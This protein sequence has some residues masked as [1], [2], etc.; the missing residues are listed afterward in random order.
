MS[1]VDRRRDIR[2]LLINTAI[3]FALYNALLTVF[4][5]FVVSRG[6]TEQQVGI[7]V[8]LFSLS[9]V[10]S[11]IYLTRIA[12]GRG[13]KWLLGVA[14]LTTITGPLLYLPDLGFWYLA[15]VRMYHAASLGAFMTAS[16]TLLADY[17]DESNR[18]QLFGLY[19]VVSGVAMAI[20]PALGYAV[21]DRLGYNAF[22]AGLALVG[23]LM[24]PGHFLLREPQVQ[25]EAEDPTS[26]LF[27]EVLRNRWVLVSSFAVFLV[28]MALGALTSFLPLHAT[29]RGISELGPYFAVFSL[30]YMTGGYGAGVLSDRWGRK[31]AAAPAFLFVV[32]GLVIL[33]QLSGFPLLLVAGLFFGLGF[34]GLNT[35][36]MA[37]VMDHTSLAQRSQAVSFYNN[38]FD[39]GSSGGAILLGGIAALSF[40]LLWTLL[41]GV[42]FLGFALICFALPRQ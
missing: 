30:M 31:I 4:P 36:L 5:L 41:A 27:Q 24:I 42:S 40:G 32:I 33:T 2:L 9:A 38:S 7:L 19:G 12:E 28:T 14:V 16:Y 39:L 21:I 10:A 29:S 17:S 35:A 34:G 6:G 15:L 26:G 20:A 1:P 11:R 18:G 3:F 23:L 22:L 8:G 25:V 37:L 13:R